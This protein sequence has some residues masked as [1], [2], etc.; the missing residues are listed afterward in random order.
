[1]DQNLYWNTGGDKYDFNGRSFSKW[2]RSGHDHHSY[3]ADPYFKDA[4]SYD[5]TFEN[6]KN[7]QRIG[8][9][10]FDYSKAG[11]YG[12]AE[13]KDKAKLAESILNNFDKVIEENM[14]KSR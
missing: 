2:K 10:P 4:I 11:V 1:M 13:W 9:E 7:I 8:F 14:L 12:S 6:E 3:I 5:F